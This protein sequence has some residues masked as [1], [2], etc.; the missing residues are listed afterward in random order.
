MWDTL[1]YILQMLS[2]QPIHWQILK[3]QCCLICVGLAQIAPTL[4]HPGILGTYFATNHRGKRVDPLKVKNCQVVK[5]IISPA[6]QVS[7]SIWRWGGTIKIRWMWDSKSW[8]SWKS[9]MLSQ[10][11]F[12]LDTKMNGICVS[13]VHGRGSR[14]RMPNENKNHFVEIGT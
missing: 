4:S 3:R 8:Q 12:P 5:K 10:K 6:P 11:M 2:I 13:F 7:V 1:I 14:V 9:H